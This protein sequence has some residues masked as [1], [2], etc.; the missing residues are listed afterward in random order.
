MMKWIATVV[1]LAFALCLFTVSPVLSEEDKEAKK[2]EE[3]QKIVLPE[4]T[5]I[6]LTTEGG[7]FFKFTGVG[8]FAAS[9]GDLATT[10]WGLRQD[11][12]YEGNP[13]S[14]HRGTRIATH[15]VAPAVVWWTTEKMHKRGRKKLALALRIGLMVAYSYAAMHNIRTVNN[16]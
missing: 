13:V 9:G 11:G 14:T 8:M 12:I 7:G 10:E 6:E 3:E 1:G 15:V 5:E 4:Q 2:D 16:P